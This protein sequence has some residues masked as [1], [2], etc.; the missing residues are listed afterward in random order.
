MSS[1]RIDKLASYNFQRKNLFLKKIMIEINEQPLNEDLKRQIYSGFGR[2]AKAIIGYDEKFDPI[3][4]IANNNGV[5][6]V[7]LL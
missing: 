6:S 7:L 1:N 3:A 2:H 5:L 4:F